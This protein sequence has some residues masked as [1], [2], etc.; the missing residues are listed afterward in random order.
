M[1]SWASAKMGLEETEGE[2]ES[3][4]CNLSCLVAVGRVLGSPTMPSQRLGPPVRPI[5]YVS[6]HA[7]DGTFIFVDQR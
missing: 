5:E 3:E 1:K 4:G 6:R 7:L 2:G